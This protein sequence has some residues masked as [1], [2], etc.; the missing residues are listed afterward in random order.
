MKLAKAM[1]AGL[2]VFAI[3]TAANAQTYIRMTGSTA[4]RSATHDAIRA[5][6]SAGHTYAYTGTSLSGANQSIFH[7][8]V[9]SDPVIFKCSWSGSVDGT[10]TVS[11]SIAIAFQPDTVVG[12]TGG[13]SGIATVTTSTSGADVSVADV[14]MSDTFQNSSP[15]TT[16]PLVETKVGIVA[17]KFVTSRGLSQLALTVDTIGGSNVYTTGSTASLA[18]GM[19]VTGANIPTASK[20]GSIIDGTQ[21]TLVD[22][23]VGVTANKNAASTTSGNACVAVTSSPINNLTPGLAQAL[24]SNGS[25]PLAL[26][27]GN[28]ADEGISVWA[29]GRDPGSGTRLVSFAESG[30]GV[31]S[32]VVQYLPTISGG[33]VTSHVPFP[34]QVV[35]GITY[36]TGN[37]GQSSGGNL[38]TYMTATTSGING[39]YVSYMGVSDATTAINGGAKE[40]SWNGV[41]Y[42]LNG[43]KNGSYPFWGYQFLAHRSSLTGTAL[44]VT[45]TL[46][47]Q[48]ITVNAP[49]KLSEMRVGR[50]S[51]GGLIT[52]NY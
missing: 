47:N 27:T 46:K 49:I 35:N 48:I 39:Y 45:N 29:T 18:V 14:G 41:Y 28:A 4:F 31:N 23:N 22:A 33:A 9:G 51:D 5:I 52:P 6:L 21:F 40:L 44:S 16:N 15:F 17:F 25:L 30:I 20:I 19:T 10:N 43:V 37:G 7:G 24:F 11:N 26:F 8:T 34:T 1:L 13:Q 38:V 42:S 3:S 36:T 32:T 50:A 2:A 12:T